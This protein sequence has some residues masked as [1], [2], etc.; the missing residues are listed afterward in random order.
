MNNLKNKIMDTGK[1]VLGVLAGLAAGAAL[2]ILFA[3]AKGSDT[4][5]MIVRK[6]ED[7]ADAIREKMEEFIDDITDKFEKVR[8]DVS[9]FVDGAQ[10]KRKEDHKTV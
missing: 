6:N 5:K 1:M 7:Y 2:G 3:P 8:V 9:E 4:R 10:A